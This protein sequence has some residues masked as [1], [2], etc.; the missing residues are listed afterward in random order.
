MSEDRSG[1]PPD[2]RFAGLTYEAFR[3][4]ASDPN[5]S[6]HERSGFPDSYRE[7][8]E[9]AILADV[10]AKLPVLTGTGATVVDLGCGAGP[11]AGEL[12][13]RCAERGHQLTLVDSPEVL[14]PAGC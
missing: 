13:R 11:L 14:A 6:S 2:Q 8:A 1:I 4:M 12:R 3:E 10:E 7:G 5:L 9:E